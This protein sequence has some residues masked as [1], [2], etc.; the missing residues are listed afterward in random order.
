ML[1]FYVRSIN[2][3][4][5]EVSQLLRLLSFREKVHTTKKNN[6]QYE[7]FV[8]LKQKL[9]FIKKNLKTVKRKVSWVEINILR[10][11]SC[12][13]KNLRRCIHI[14]E[15][16]SKNLK[17]AINEIL[18]EENKLFWNRGEI[19]EESMKEIENKTNTFLTLA[20]NSLCTLIKLLYEFLH[21]L[22]QGVYD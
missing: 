4:Y 3:T 11:G 19:S 12:D 8:W 9:V 20:K 18:K 21:N 15:T 5:I 6:G 2:D 17:I 7:R 16:S 1:S 22:R 10:D 13:I 14:F